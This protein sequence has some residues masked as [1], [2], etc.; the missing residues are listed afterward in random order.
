VSFS[1]FF[2]FF[3][4]FFSLR[5]L[6]FIFS[7][8]DIATG[9]SILFIPRLS[10]DYAVWLGEIKPL[11]Y[12]K[13]IKVI[14]SLKR[15]P[16]IFFQLMIMLFCRNNTWLAWYTTPM[17]LPWFCMTISKDLENPCFYYMG[18]TL[19]AINMQNQQSLRSL[20]L[21]LAFSS[22]ITSLYLQNRVT[23]Q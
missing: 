20:Q 16:C 7:M 8:K 9:E 18:L 17:R 6:V 10:A 2:F 1:N 3:F 13:V 22:Q 4:N 14:C 23:D 5:T 11:S 15:A 12:Y 19:T 21:A